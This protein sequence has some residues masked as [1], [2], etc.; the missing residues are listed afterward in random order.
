M[1]PPL[2]LPLLPDFQGVPNYSYCLTTYPVESP[3]AFLL[4]D[5]YKISGT[6]LPGGI[7]MSGTTLH[8]NLFK[9][10]KG[11]PHNHKLNFTLETGR[12]QKFTQ[13]REFVHATYMCYSETPPNN[14][15]TSGI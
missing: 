12:E 11:I 6:A 9:G 10:E 14:S 8:A 7:G 2:N 13:E 4:V 15:Q 5:L 3:E 1:A